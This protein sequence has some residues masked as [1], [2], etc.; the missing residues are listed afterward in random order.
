M[1]V[2]PDELQDCD[3]VIQLVLDVCRAEG[4]KE[5]WFTGDQHHNH[6]LV[7]L[8]VL[9]W[10]L[11]TF[12]ALKD[13]GID[14][15]CLVGNHDQSAP[16]SD[17]H[18]MMAYQGL[19]HVKVIDR[20]TIHRNVLMVP[21]M[22]DEDKFQQACK[23][24]YSDGAQYT[25]F[26]HQTFDGSTYENG[27]LASDG[28]DPNLLPQELLISGHIHTG[29]EYGKVWYVGAPRWRSIHD[30]NTEKSIWVLEFED[31]KLV[32]R[33]PYSTGTVCRQ[34]R[35]V[36]DTPDQPVQLPLDGRH[37]WCI[38]IKGPPD[39]CQQRKTEL[40]AAGARVRTFPTQVSSVGRVRE[41][42]G[43]GCAFRSYLGVFQ[44]KYGTPTEVLIKMAKERL[45]V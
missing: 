7:R 8:S 43:I 37:Q 44:P 12:Q 16:G 2:V 9:H 33:K 6:D 32:G 30:A 36:E 35:H 14:S 29:Q 15:V 11:T 25:V 28:F 39:W 18:A 19:Q 10:W 17:V 38:D 22:H 4:I 40:G 3:A 31:G 5:L 41:S 24:G 1:H 42:E 21:Y 45:N 27:F 23:D 20:P 26:C 34:I 13:Q